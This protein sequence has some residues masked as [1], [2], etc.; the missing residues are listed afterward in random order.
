MKLFDLKSS[1]KEHGKVLGSQ[2]L[3]LVLGFCANLFC[4][5]ALLADHTHEHG[6][7]HHHGSEESERGLLEQARELQR[8]HRFQEAASLLAKHIESRP[9]DLEAQLLHAD[10][11]IHAGQNDEARRACIRVA[12]SGSSTLASYCAIQLLLAEGD[13]TKA[14]ETS[15]A[16]AGEIPR[17]QDDAQVWALEISAEAAWRAGRT[18]AAQAL[19]EK[20]LTYSQLPHSALDAYAAFS[21]AQHSAGDSAT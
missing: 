19:Y 21:R 9:F 20:L 2:M 16:L 14:D 10:V 13:Y 5:P 3:V 8:D 11:L 18:D 12:V 6:H 4:A 17:L 7:D 1:L 15:Q